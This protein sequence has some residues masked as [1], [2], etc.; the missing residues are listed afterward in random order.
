MPADLGV[1]GLA[2]DT[3][4]ITA[5]CDLDIETALYLPQV[6]IKLTAEIGETVIIGGLEDNVSRNLDSVQSIV[7]ISA[8][9]QRW[10]VR[11]AAA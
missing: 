8:K 2:G 4:S 5:A 7:E 3:E 11:Q 10:E 6:F 9:F 1:A